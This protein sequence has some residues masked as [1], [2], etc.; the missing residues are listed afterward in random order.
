[1]K[2]LHSKNLLDKKQII[3]SVSLLLNDDIE[4]TVLV[5]KIM[6]IILKMEGVLQFNVAPS[7]VI[8]MNSL[9]SEKKV[10]K[11]CFLAHIIFER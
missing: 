10:D 2:S 9:I 6:N 4:I 3:E 8:I 1:M 11:I 5:L 7:F